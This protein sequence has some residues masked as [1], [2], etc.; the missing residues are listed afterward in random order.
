MSLE[1]GKTLLHYEI[2]GKIGEGGMGSVFMALQKEPVRR[3]VALKVIKPGMDSR[4]VVSRFEA[5]RGRETFF[6]TGT[7]EHGDKIVAAAEKENLSPRTYVDNISKLFKDLWPE[8]NIQNDY[9]VRTTDKAHISTVKKILQAIYDS[10][11]I[12]FSEYE[13]ECRARQFRSICHQ[14]AQ[15]FNSCTV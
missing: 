9:F 11:D 15:V 13:G 14:C 5:M 7:D 10:G 1:P 8:L 3:K 6:L 4:Q 12:Y 2:T